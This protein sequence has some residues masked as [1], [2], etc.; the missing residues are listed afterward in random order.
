[1]SARKPL[2][3]GLSA[4]VLAACDAVLGLG[5]L[6]DRQPD[7]SA[8]DSG[9]SALD[10]GGETRDATS[11]GPA[12]NTDAGSAGDANECPGTGG[13]TMVR[14]PGGCIDSTEVTNRQYA[15]FLTAPPNLPPQ[16]ACAWSTTFTPGCSWPVASTRLDNPVGCVNWCQAQAFC[17]WAGKRLCTTPFWTSACTHGGLHQYPYGDTFEPGSCNVDSSGSWPVASHATC[18][19]GYPGIFDLSGNLFEWGADC[20]GDGGATDNCPGLGG[21]Y[22]TNNAC[23][24]GGDVRTRVQADT[25]IRCCTD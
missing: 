19:G 23:N 18:E 16:P 15:E 6:T 5:G 22:D 3:V 7:G 4:L 13:P 17:A 14:V 25:G 1:M 21:S 9:G 11:D 20:T 8:L 12:T 24:A 2:V 10:G